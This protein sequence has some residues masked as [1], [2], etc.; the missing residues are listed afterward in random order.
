[1]PSGIPSKYRKHF[2]KFP[3]DEVARRVASFGV[4]SS[5][6]NRLDPVVI[7]GLEKAGRYVTVGRSRPWDPYINYLT[8]RTL[9]DLKEW[10]G[11]PN[12]VAQYSDPVSFI[13]DGYEAAARTIDGEKVGLHHL[14]TARSF[15]FD[16]LHGS[17]R[18][19][20]R[21]VAQRLLYGVTEPDAVG[22]PPLAA[23]VKYMLGAAQRLPAFM[24]PDLLVCPDHTVSFPNFAVL[25]FNNV[26]VVGS[27]QIVLGRQAKLH[28]LQITHA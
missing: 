21:H 27:G 24:A 8:P 14:P 19:A 10:V 13:R 15:T 6:L 18:T 3:E 28:A 12:S 17:Q 5:T 9:D 2:K 25:Y 22:R 7:C 23:V 11:V 16:R 1:M 20:V 26:V 4:D